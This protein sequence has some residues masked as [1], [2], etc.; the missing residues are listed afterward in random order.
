MPPTTNA[1]KPDEPVTAP[2]P[3]SSDERTLLEKL[4]IRASADK[5]PANRIGEPYEALIN[6]SVPRRGDRDHASDLVFRGETVYLT[7]EEARAFNRKGSRDGRQVDVVR[8][9]SGP[10][11]SHAQVPLLLPRAVSGRL[12]RPPPPVPGSDL[13]RPDPPGSSGIQEMLDGGAPEMAGAMT[14]DPSEMA[15]HLSDSV[16]QDA[17][18]LPPSRARARR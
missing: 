11:G 12:F 13:P 14:G 17:L 3:L 16:A 5:T 4:L 6:L 15:S 7:D 9:L 18:D 8:K 2:D 10:E 1:V